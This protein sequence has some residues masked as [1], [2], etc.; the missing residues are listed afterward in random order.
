MT[1]EENNNSK[2][3]RIVCKIDPANKELFKEKVSKCIEYNNFSV[4]SKDVKGQKSLPLPVSQEKN[5]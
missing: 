5:E 2:Y 1:E 4:R 3:I